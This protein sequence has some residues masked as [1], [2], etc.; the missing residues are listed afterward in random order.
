MSKVPLKESDVTSDWL[1]A[2]LVA[3]PKK[4]SEVTVLKLKPIKTD[5]YL[6][7]AFQ[8]IVKIDGIEQK[9][10]IKISLPC[11]DPFQV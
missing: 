2:T 8:A 6:S 10:F 7:K 3:S 1:R 9:L 5:G 4:G 11:E